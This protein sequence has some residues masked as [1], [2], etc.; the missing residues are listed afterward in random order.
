[1]QNLIEYPILLKYYY[2][3]NYTIDTYLVIAEDHF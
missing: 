1:M 3:K 2:S